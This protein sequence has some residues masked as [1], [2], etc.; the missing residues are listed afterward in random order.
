MKQERRVWMR[1]FKL[2]M[3]YEGTR[4]QGWQRLGNTEQTITGKLEAVL[5]R[6]LG[7]SI[8]VHGS[9]RTDAGVH[10]LGQV[11]HFKADTDMSA[12]EI[13]TYLNR[14]LPMDIRILS[15]QEM[16]LR[17]HSRLHAVSKTYC[18]RLYL[19]EKPPV[20][21]RNTLWCIG[22]ELDLEAMERGAA[23][24]LGAHD[25]QS[26]CAAKRGKK[27]T[28]RT[29]YE[30][31][32]SSQGDLVTLRVSGNGFLYHMVRILA[33]TLVEIG[34]GV[35]SADSVPGL[36]QAKDRT[37]AGPTLP[38]CGLTLMEVRYPESL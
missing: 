18:Y 32:V 29:I 12:E 20:F 31:S 21:E 25:F 5:E 36:L 8:E 28:V 9:G 3:E 30:C 10:A 7:R 6:M 14:Y 33:G 2:T 17:F 19:G 34:E 35:R 37:L 22:H 15:V 16:P 27:S 11:A 38:S 1:N 23:D 24:C 13:F 4:Y 26:F